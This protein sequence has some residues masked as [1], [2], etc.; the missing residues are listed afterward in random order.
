[1]TLRRKQ[2]GLCAAL[3]AGA[4]ATSLPLRVW[5]QPPV[6]VLVSSDS[7]AGWAPSDAQVSQAKEAALAF[8]AALDRGDAAKAYAS[9]SELN[10]QQQP[11]E[12]YQSEL[13]KFNAEAGPVRERRITTITWTKDPP[14]APAKGVYAAVDLVSRFAEVDRHCG[15]LMLYQP[16]EGLPFTVMRQESNFIVNSAATAME[17]M[18]SKAALD[19]T[20]LTMVAKCP[21]FPADLKPAL[22]PLAE[23][24][25]KTFGY[26]S[27]AAALT[28][29]RAKP[30]VKISQ[31][32]GWTMIEDT[33]AYTL[34][35]FAPTSD[36]AYPAAIKRQVANDA[37]QM[38][39]QTSIQCEADKVACDNFAR[40]LVGAQ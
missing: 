11:L 35:A 9:L 17:K 15:Y 37:G 26:P 20:W 6:Q 23:A 32:D 38:V 40:P 1:M 18:Q 16:E 2:L 19:M 10:R 4:L 8:L 22:P 24:K 31:Q 13:R 30:G 12:A 33:A 25:D 27:I 5:A 14:N 3:A 36:P 21:N 39:I 7:P 29:L 34:W 28:A